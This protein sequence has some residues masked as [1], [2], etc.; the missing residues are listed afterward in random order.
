[1]ECSQCGKPV[2]RSNGVCIIGNVM[3]GDGVGGVVGRSYKGC[4]P[5][6]STVLRSYYH[7][8]CLNGVIGG[9]S[10]DPFREDRIELSRS[11]NKKFI[12]YADALLT[13]TPNTIGILRNLVCMGSQKAADLL[14]KYECLNFMEKAIENGRSNV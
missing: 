5:P 12:V 2:T 13:Y 7:A 14:E 8:E 9:F 3:S 10:T 6:L 11:L 4:D 1:M